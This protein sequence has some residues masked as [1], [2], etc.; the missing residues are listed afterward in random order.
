MSSVDGSV[1]TTSAD[2]SAEVSSRGLKA[3]DCALRVKSLSLTFANGLK[4][5]DGIDFSV[6]DGGEN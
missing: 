5:F 2:Q 1:G 4:I 3:S 6:D